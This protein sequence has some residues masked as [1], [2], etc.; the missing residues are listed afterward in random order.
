M[1][2]KRWLVYG[3]AGAL[4]VTAAACGSLAPNAP[5]QMSDEMKRLRAEFKLYFISYRDGSRELYM[6]EPDGTN[7]RR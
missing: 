2:F 3:A 4:A 5:L 7:Q 1:S 6:M